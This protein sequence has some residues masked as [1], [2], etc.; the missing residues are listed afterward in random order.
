ML[1]TTNVS[2][3]LLS[4]FLFVFSATLLFSQGSY[5]AQVRGVVADANGGVV[6]NAKVTITDV[7]TGVSTTASTTDCTTCLI[8]SGSIFPS[9]W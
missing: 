3:L 7:G 6:T 5:R 1:R 4:A 8:N 9:S 2:R